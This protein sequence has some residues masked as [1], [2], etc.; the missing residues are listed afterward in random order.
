[1]HLFFQFFLSIKDYKMVEESI[2]LAN[3]E[4]KSHYFYHKNVQ[5]KVKFNIKSFDDYFNN[6]YNTTQLDIKQEKISLE[7]Y[8]QCN[9]MKCRHLLHDDFWIKITS[10]SNKLDKIEDLEEINEIINEDGT[11]IFVNS[12][13]S[14]DISNIEFLEF[15]NKLNQNTFNGYSIEFKYIDFDEDTDNIKWII[16]ICKKDD[17]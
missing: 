9:T 10:K 8:I 13:N 15:V 14:D 2:K 11:T 5:Q 12:I 6:N 4:Y 7:K 3:L 17:M 16:I 1:M